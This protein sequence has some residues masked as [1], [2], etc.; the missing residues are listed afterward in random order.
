VVKLLLKDLTHRKQ[1]DRSPRP[2][3]QT[4]FPS[5]RRSQWL[6]Y[7]D[8]DDVIDAACYE[9]ETRIARGELIHG[10]AL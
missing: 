6:D 7:L 1:N 2:V 3:R 10:R 9:L 4:P 8:K 5:P